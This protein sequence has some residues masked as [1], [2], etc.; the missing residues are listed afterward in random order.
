M[1]T[2]IL[3]I[4]WPYLQRFLT[5]R[6]AEYAADYLQTRREQRLMKRASQEATETSLL[7]ETET[8]S[9]IEILA[10]S[11]TSDSF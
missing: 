8:D 10:G 5:K 4:A 7:E 1:Y 9:T 11:P 3:K 2:T 6:A